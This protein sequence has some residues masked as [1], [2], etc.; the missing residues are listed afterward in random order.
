MSPTSHALIDLTD[1]QR[2]ELA[3]LVRAGSTAQRLALRAVI[4]LMV[5][6]T[7]TAATTA[8]PPARDP[9]MHPF[10]S[11]S[12]WNMP[13]GDGA[14]YVPANLPSVPGGHVWS[15]MP[16]VDDDIIILKPTAPLTSVKYSNAGWSGSD[17]CTGDSQTLAQ[18][19][20]PSE[21]RVGNSRDNNSAAILLQDGRT[22]A[23]MQPFTRC[24][25]GGAATSLLTFPNVDIYSDGISGSHGG[26]RMSALGGTI[27]FGELR[28]GQQGPRHA[29]KVNVNSAHDLYNCATFTD[30]YRWPA[31]TA[32]SGAQSKYGTDGNSQNKAMKMGSLLALP[33]TVDINSMG[34]RSDPGRQLA[35]TLQNYG[36]YIVDSTGGPAFAIEAELGPA[37][38][39][40]AQ[41]QSDY[42]YPLEQRVRDKTPW[43]TDMQKIVAALA[44]VNNNS[45]TSVGGGGT[46]RQPLAAP[47]N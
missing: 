30:C 14:V 21:F 11:T 32:D 47:F 15:P 36:A 45:A 20:I 4:V 22:I 18:V 26:S 2:R 43:S 40:R 41:F 24:T 28:P 9:L 37:N 13:I 25:A 31:L 8:P 46:P 5:T 39:V 19:P 34:L 6:Q 10:S 44:V 3:G 38:S 33:A 29:L 42:G 12:I 27:R 17:R 23:Q 7:V 16:Q 35:W 1:P